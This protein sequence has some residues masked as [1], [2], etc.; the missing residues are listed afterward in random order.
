MKNAMRNNLFDEIHDIKIHAGKEPISLSLPQR[1]KQTKSY[2]SPNN[3]TRKTGFS[4]KF[5]RQLFAFNLE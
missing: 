4:I 1:N 3:A 5:S 2:Q